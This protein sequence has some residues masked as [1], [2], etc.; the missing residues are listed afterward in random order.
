MVIKADVSL[1]AV[2]DV[3]IVCCERKI[4]AH[5]VLKVLIIPICIQ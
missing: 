4:E 1:F 5:V 2:T 3:R